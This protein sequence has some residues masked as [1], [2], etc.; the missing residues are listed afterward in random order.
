MASSDSVK[1][2]E[3]LAKIQIYNSRPLD[4]IEQVFYDEQVTEIGRVMAEN[5]KLQNQLADALKRIE[6]LKEIASDLQDL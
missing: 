6:G 1:R 2:I 3:N 4:N 5:A